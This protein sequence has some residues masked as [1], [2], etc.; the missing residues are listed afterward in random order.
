MR[1][2]FQSPLARWGFTI[3]ALVAWAN[4]LTAPFIVSAC[5]AAIAWHTRP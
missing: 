2:P 5:L 1:Q 4:Q 3:C